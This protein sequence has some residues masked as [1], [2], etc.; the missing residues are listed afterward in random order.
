[1]ELSDFTN[2]DNDYDQGE[3]RSTQRS[4]EGTGIILDASESR[5]RSEQGNLN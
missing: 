2:E 4:F 3:S 1:M 5:Q